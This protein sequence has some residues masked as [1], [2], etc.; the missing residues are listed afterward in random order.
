[1][2]KRTNNS[3]M[4]SA[5]V[6]YYDWGKYGLKAKDTKR[7]LTVEMKDEVLY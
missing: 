7:L 1:M 5:I 3:H 2:F 4:E 6:W